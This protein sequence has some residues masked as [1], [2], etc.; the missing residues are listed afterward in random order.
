MVFVH[1]RNQTVKTANF[2]KQTAAK[3][4]LSLLFQPDKDP[5]NTEK[6]RWRKNHLWKT[7]NSY[8]SELFSHGLGVHHAGTILNTKLNKQN[9][10]TNEH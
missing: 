4:N 7:K 1:A 2:L 10:S 5:Q 3:Q 8:L 6:C 9:R